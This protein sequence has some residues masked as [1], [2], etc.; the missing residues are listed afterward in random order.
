MK[1]KSFDR[2]KIVH[3]QSE[4]RATWFFG[5]PGHHKRN[6]TPQD[7]NFNRPVCC[8]YSLASMVDWVPPDGPSQSPLVLGRSAQAS[9]YAPRL[10]E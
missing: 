8:V 2:I 3:L 5:V 10:A 4:F 9:R 1:Y 6:S 7:D